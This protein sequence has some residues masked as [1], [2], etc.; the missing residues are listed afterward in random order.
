M[1]Q[2]SEGLAS[3]LLK[4]R[5]NAVL[6]SVLMVSRSLSTYLQ[7]SCYEAWL[8]NPARISQSVTTRPWPWPLA[9][10]LRHQFLG[11]KRF[12]WTWLPVNWGL[13]LLPWH[14]L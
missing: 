13:Q 11:V 5:L 3:D 6:L 4:V 14:P 7:V 1:W 10:W 8:A 12:S 9:V 2:L